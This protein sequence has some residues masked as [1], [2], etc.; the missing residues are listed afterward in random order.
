MAG[1]MVDSWQLATISMWVDRLN[2]HEVIKLI[3]DNFQFDVLW[4]AAEEVNKLCKDRDMNTKIPKNRDQGDQKD[5][6]AVLSNAMLISLAELKSRADRPVY[7]VSS[8]NLAQV[9]GTVKDCVQAEPAVTARLDNIE[10]MIE[11]LNKGL[12]DLQTSKPAQWPA[13]QVNGVSARALGTPPGRQGQ[14]LQAAGYAGGQVQQTLGARQR[15]KSPS[16]KRSAGEAQLQEGDRQADQDVPWSQVLGRN[17]GRKPRIVQYGTAKVNVAGAEAKPYDVVIGNT[18][19][20]STDKIIKEVLIEIAEN[21][22][23]ENKLEEPL[24]ILEVE[25]LTK[26]RTDGS[27]IWS[28]SWRVQVPNKFREYMQC[29]E[30]YPAGWTTRKYFPPR[31]QRPAVPALYPGSATQPPEKRPNLN[32]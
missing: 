20:G 15:E 6:V 9:P 16:F 18:N 10:R 4:E 1:A 2:H 24:D 23:G 32:H 27:R 17:Q 26:P 3:G 8:S 29:P 31:Q 25:C 28:R 5:R 22:T 13:L 11:N 30:A 7:V 19:P 21:M 14:L 12:N